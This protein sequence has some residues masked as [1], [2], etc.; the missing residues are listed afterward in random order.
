MSPNFLSLVV[1]GKRNISNEK[2]QQV[3]SVL[4]LPVSYIYV[5]ADD[6]PETNP[7]REMVKTHLNSRTN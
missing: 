1:R 4:R 3:A 7:L 5:L 2:L 6:S